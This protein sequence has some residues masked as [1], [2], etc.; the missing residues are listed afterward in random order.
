MTNESIF[1]GPVAEDFS[2]DIAA[3]D[4]SF[5]VSAEVFA[6]AYQSFLAE[7]PQLLIKPAIAILPNELIDELAVEFRAVGYDQSF[8]LD[9]KRAM[10]QRACADNRIRGTPFSVQQLCNQ[11]FGECVV[12]EWW[13]YGGQPYRFRILTTDPAVDPN[14]IAIL[15]AAIL[16]TK[17][18]S[19]WPDAI[20]RSRNVGASPPG[21]VYLGAGFFRVRHRVMPPVSYP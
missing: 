6:Q 5:K 19:R 8:P 20:S 21:T 4:P 13:E 1:N 17:P 7:L 16:A 9:Q 2:P 3:Q 11:V 14:R 18:V 12:Q 10:V 15:N